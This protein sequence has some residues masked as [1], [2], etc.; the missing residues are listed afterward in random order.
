MI[1]RLLLVAVLAFGAA[2]PAFA[3]EN[4]SR[5]QFDTEQQRERYWDLLSQLRCLVCQNESLADSQADLARDLRQQV[6]E[7]MHAGKSND[8]I[9]DYLV[10]RYGDFVLFRPPVEPGTYLLWFGPALIFLIGLGFGIRILAQ[11]RGTQAQLSEEDRRRAARL[12]NDEDGEPR[13]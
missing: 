12:L 10:D 8:A 7:Q 6:Y 9:V 13:Q 5:Y 4:A 1:A 11:R 2:W 3:V